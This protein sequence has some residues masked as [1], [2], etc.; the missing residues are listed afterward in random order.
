MYKGNGSTDGIYVHLGFRPALVIVKNMDTQKH[1]GLYDNKRSGFNPNNHGLFPSDKAAEDT[2]EYIDF[3]SDGFK[4]RSSALFQN[5]DGDNLIYMA[6][7]EA[8]DATPFDTFPN[9][10]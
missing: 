1:W 3:L 9:A 2:S 6:F 8:T 4:L 5:K 10:R 7:A